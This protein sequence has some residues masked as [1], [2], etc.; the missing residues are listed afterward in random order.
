[1]GVARPIF[2]YIQSKMVDEI[3]SP[4]YIQ[5]YTLELIIFTHLI[6]FNEI[7]T[8]TTSAHSAIRT[9]F[10]LRILDSKVYFW[11]HCDLVLCL[12]KIIVFKI[13]II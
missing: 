12:Q 1:M 11:N 7:T 4:L 9:C 13:T 5:G 2:F 3:A 10:T 6:L 8:T